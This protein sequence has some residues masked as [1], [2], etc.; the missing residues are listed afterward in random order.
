MRWTQLL[1][2][3]ISLA[4]LFSLGCAS[5]VLEYEHAK[6]IQ[7]NQEFDQ[8]VKVKVLEP[9]EPALVSDDKDKSKINAKDE[10]LTQDDLVKDIAPAQKVRAKSKKKDISRITEETPVEKMIEKKSMEDQQ[11][12]TPVAQDRMPKFEDNVGFNDRR[13]VID[14][15]RAGEKVTLALTYFNVAAGYLDLGVKPFVE[16][17]EQKAYHFYAH[18]KSSN[19]FS[20]FYSVNDT[21]ETFVD[22]ETLR[23]Q[24]LEIHVKESKQLNEI[25]TFFDWKKKQAKY[26]SKK[27][28]DD[29]EEET[30]KLA[31][32]I[33]NYA[34]NVISAAFYLRVFQLEPG[35]D[36]EFRVADAGKNLIFKG[37]VL[38]RETIDTEL[39]ELKTIVV[40]PEIEQDGIFKPVGDI[41]LW[42]TDDDRKFI[43]KIEA[44][45]KIGTIIGKLKAIEKGFTSQ[46]AF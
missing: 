11:T 38:R 14:P 39:G 40:K 1:F 31:W 45:I 43:V 27:V 16:V 44:K 21:A 13:P 26:W 18:V 36:L 19:V 8:L 4:C 20:Y 32:E 35:K 24:T 33:E 12:K 15:F 17:N 23:P 5:K 22:Y 30:K 37:K 46:V 29:K 10:D 9:V 6:E 3:L 42:L 34:Q 28:N 41:F 2:S 7:Q 25:R